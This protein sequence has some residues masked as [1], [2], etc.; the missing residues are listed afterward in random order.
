MGAVALLL[1]AALAPLASELGA[2]TRVPRVVV[3][4]PLS[5]IPRNDLTF[6]TLLRGFAAHVSPL[7]QHRAAVFELRGPADT[8]VRVE[9][10]LP[11]ALIAQAGTTEIPL[12]FGAADG[13]A[14]LTGTWPPMGTLFNPRA[15]Y[16]GTLG[17]NGRIFL[18][19][20]GTAT[21]RQQQPNGIYSGAIY[22]TMFNL[23]S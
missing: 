22:L 4:E 21:P 13:F 10:A 15:P 2:Q 9:I 19:I 23:G 6:G 5:V 8:P 3:P 12:S 20:G 18:R 16:I 17:P 7:D 1:A 14:D 11:P